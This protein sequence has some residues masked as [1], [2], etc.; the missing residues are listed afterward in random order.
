MG[1]F[2]RTGLKLLAVMTITLFTANIYGQPD[3]AGVYEAF[4]QGVQMMKI[5]P[6]AAVTS[7][8][9]AIGLANQVG[10]DEAID[11]KDQAMKQIPK[12]YW[13]S[14]KNLAG[15]KDYDAAIAKLDACI[16]SSNRVDDKSQA[17]R[18]LST[19]VSIYNVQGTDAFTSNDSEAALEYFD[20]AISRNSGY[21][22]AYLGK[23]LTYD[24]IGDFEKMEEAAL[25]GLEASN[26][27]R[28]SK[29]AGDIQQKLRGTFFNLA[30]ENMK[31]QDYASAA[32]NLSKSIEYGNNNA[33]TYY[34]LGLAYKGQNRWNEAIEAYNRS[35]ELDLGSDA[36]KA[37]I[38]FELGGA[39]QSISDNARACESY[40]KALHGQFEEAA[41]YQ[42]ENILNCGN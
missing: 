23:V 35:L 10:S 29:T 26:T 25:L 17:S 15:K 13:E 16:E 22:K 30:Q 8:E 39:Y 18:A 2:S 3:M 5:N 4:N 7:F 9:K 19:I 24:E 6:D 11:V 33:L 40:K 21:A 34:Q 27:S 32:Q 14:A 41:K 20:K 38:Y 1:D 37:K 12:I 42:I 31:D 36:D 28:D